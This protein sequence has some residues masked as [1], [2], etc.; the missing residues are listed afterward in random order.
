MPP[1]YDRTLADHAKSFVVDGGQL[2]F[3]VDTDW[4][5]HGLLPHA[6]DVQ[7]RENNQVMLY[8]GTTRPLVGRI[9][10]GVDLTAADAYRGWCGQVA[11]RLLQ[12][13]PKPVPEHVQGQ[14][15]EYLKLAVAAL[16]R[17]QPSHFSKEGYWQNRLALTWGRGWRETDRFL[18]FDREVVLG[19]VNEE[20]RRRYFDPLSLPYDQAAE[21]IRAG[22]GAAWAVRGEDKHRELDLLAV[23]AEGELVC[24][25]LKH[26]SSAG[27]IYWGPLQVGPDR[28]AMATA[29][30][31]IQDGL[32]ALIEQKI[33][34]GLLPAAAR[35]RLK[36]KHFGRVSGALV[37]AEPPPRRSKVWPRLHAVQE[38]L[39]ARRVEVIT[40]EDS[41]GDVAMQEWQP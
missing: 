10:G 2:R 22:I 39:G 9:H 37:V 6:I 13:W 28:D 35:N 5:R 30:P 18:V 36:G 41:G 15:T 23:D 25:E 24:I 21:A 20:A 3:L 34:L 12:P 26:G 14:V 32:R 8:H 16:A 7:L 40:V 19:F 33:E 1:R 17:H 11:T 4:S 29:L 38:Q 27:G 31:H